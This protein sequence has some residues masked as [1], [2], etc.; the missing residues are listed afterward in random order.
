M[1][2]KHAGRTTDNELVSGPFFEMD[3]AGFYH[4]GTSVTYSLADSPFRTPPSTHPGHPH[5]THY[6]QQ[7]VANV[8]HPELTS[9]N[10]KLDR[11][12]AVVLEQKETGRNFKAMCFIMAINLLP[13][14]KLQSKRRK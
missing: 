12:L 2:K 5:P 11:V 13:L 1:R 14:I 3:T 4:Q 10:Q 7:F 9:V 6:G 8:G